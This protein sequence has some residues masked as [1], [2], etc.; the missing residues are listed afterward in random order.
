MQATPTKQPRPAFVIR[1]VGS[2][3]RPWRVPMRSL[4]RVLEAVQ[5]LVERRDEFDD[6]TEEQDVVQGETGKIL[7]L[8]KVTSGSAAY[9][10]AAP[11]PKNTLRVLQEMQEAIKQ[12]ENVDWLDSTLSSVKE[13]SEV[14]K[15]MG[16]EIEFCE[17]S[18]RKGGVIAKIT[19]ATYSEI[20]GS[21]YINAETSVYAKIERVGGV[22]EMGCGIRLPSAPRKMVICRVKTEDVVRNLGQYMY[23]F[24]ILH[25][26]ATWSRYNWRLKR[27][28]IDSF[29]PPKKGS[30]RE[31]LRT[32]HQAG[33]CPWDA[34]EDPEAFIAEIRGA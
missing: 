6:D 20:E 7:H 1:L 15:S 5:R 2:E 33:G 18:K 24:V 12:P 4:A 34:I 19:P 26:Q 27:L 21:A 28:V 22:T 8:L 23:E 29:D 32:S 13:F 16:C 3:I 11:N 30:I 31:A 25:G 17:P 14:A 9:A 10:V